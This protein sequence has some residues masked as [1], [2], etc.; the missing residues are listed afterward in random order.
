MLL[1]LEVML[2]TDFVQ[3]SGTNAGT[4]DP[5]PNATAAIVQAFDLLQNQVFGQLLLQT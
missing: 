3:R 4:A 2:S 1:A 5:G